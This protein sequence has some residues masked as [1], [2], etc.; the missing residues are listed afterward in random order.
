M[1]LID[2]N[3]TVKIIPNHFRDLFEFH[4]KQTLDLCN[5]GCFILTWNSL[6][7]GKRL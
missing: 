4:I 3:K 5:P 7:I 6:N 1:L 2:F